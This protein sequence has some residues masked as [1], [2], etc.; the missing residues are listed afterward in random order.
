MRN[1]KNITSNKEKLLSRLRTQYPELMVEWDE[2]RGVAFFVHR[3][4]NDKLWG[5]ELWH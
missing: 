3:S 1:M 5:G 2:V 4:A